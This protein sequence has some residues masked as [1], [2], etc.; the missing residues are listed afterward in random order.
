MAGLGLG[1]ELL[2]PPPIPFEQ[3]LLLLLDFIPPSDKYDICCSP[4]VVCRASL[5]DW[6]NC[7][8]VGIGPTER[9]GD[10]PLRRRSFATATKL[11]GLQHCGHGEIVRN[12][13]A[14]F[15][16]R[17]ENKIQIEQ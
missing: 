8:G 13:L 12:R 2:S 4:K 15:I 9:G 14:R 10:M 7:F 6:E 3:R 1:L 17:D 11:R 16:N 5:S